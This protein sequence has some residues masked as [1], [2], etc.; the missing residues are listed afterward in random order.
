MLA[1]LPDAVRDGIAA[2]FAHSFRTLYLAAAAICGGGLVLALLHQ[3]I[4]AARA[5]AAGAG[6]DGRDA[7]RCGRR[8]ARR[9]ERCRRRLS[10]PPA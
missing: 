8:R 5:P 7:P 2:S 9:P 6:A 4:A 10:V 1:A 3:G